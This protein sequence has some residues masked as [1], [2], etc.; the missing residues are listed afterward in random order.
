MPVGCLPP[1]GQILRR[2]GLRRVGRGEA[3]GGGEEKR[4]EGRLWSGCKIIYFLKSDACVL[5]L[6]QKSW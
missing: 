6:G 3:V 2:N 1:L 4:R 5:T